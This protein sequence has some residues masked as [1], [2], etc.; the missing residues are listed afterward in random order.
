MVQVTDLVVYDIG[1]QYWE[2]CVVQETDQV[3]DS[4]IELVVPKGLVWR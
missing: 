3:W 1:S 2:I 4:V